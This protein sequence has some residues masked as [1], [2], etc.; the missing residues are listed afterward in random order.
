MPPTAWERTLPFCHLDVGHHRQLQGLDLHPQPA[1]FYVN[2]MFFLLYQLISHW[3]AGEGAMTGSVLE[4]L[5]TS[6][7]NLP[8]TIPSHRRL[9]F[10]V[11]KGD[12]SRT[13]RQRAAD[14]QV[15]N[16]KLGCLPALLCAALEYQGDFRHWEWDLEVGRKRQVNNL[17]D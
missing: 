2:F 8:Q 7:L 1:V 6:L 5:L 11:I 16:H 17:Q 13:F 12:Q 14:L 3:G 4:N 10:G 9:T 15:R